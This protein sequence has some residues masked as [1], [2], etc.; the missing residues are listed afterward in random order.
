MAL[1]ALGARVEIPRLLRIGPRPLVLGLT[2]WA[3]IAAVAY[4]GVRI[5]WT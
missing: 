1:F 4:A 5:A 3:L 2:S